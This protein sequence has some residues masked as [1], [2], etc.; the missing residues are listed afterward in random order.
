M[1]KTNNSAEH[2]INREL[3]WL[4]F[5]ARVLEEAVDKRNPLMERL[6]FTAI[7]SSNFDEFFMVR[8][9]S[10]GDQIAA[11]FTKKD[12]S[13]LDP[14]EQMA[15][16]SQRVHG[17]I[18]EQY[19]CFNRS[20]MSLLKKE[21]IIRLE[22]GQ[23]NRQ[24]KDYLKQYFTNRVFPVLTPMVVDQSRPFPLIHNRRLNIALLLEKDGNKEQTLFA[25]VEIPSVLDRL[26]LLPGVGSEKT[27]F[28]LEDLII[29]ELQTLFKGHRIQKMGL[30]RIT[31]NADL[32]YDEEGAED[33]LLTIQESVK[34]RK[35]GSVVRL[36]VQQDLDVFL[37]DILTD[38]LEVYHDAVYEIDGPLDLTFLTAF[39]QMKPF[40]YLRYAPQYPQPL[41]ALSEGEELF[42]TLDRGDVLLHHPYQSFDPVVQ[43]VQLAACDPNVLAI[44]QTLYRVSGNS[45]IIEALAVA[46][47]NGKQVTVLVEL[48][49]RFDE[50]NNILWAKRLEKSGCHVIYGLVGLKTHC[51]ML[52]IVKRSENGIKRYLHMSTGNYNDDTARFYVD[53]GF[54]TSNP[55]FC[56][57]AS[58]IFNMMS[59]YSKLDELYKLML[60][61]LNL[62]QTFLELIEQETRNTAN[63]D[64]GHIIVKV[65]SLVDTELIEA[66]Y[67]AS[68]AGVKIQLLVRGMCCLRPGLPGVSENIEVRSIVAR[69]LEHSRIFYFYH[70]GEELTFL[71]SADWM[72]RN[73]DRRVEVM[74]PVEDL[75]IKAQ[76]KNILD[77][78]LRDTAH[79]RILHADG[80][81]KKINK[82]GKAHFD[83]QEYFYRQAIEEAARIHHQIPDSFESRRKKSPE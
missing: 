19:H 11:G 42:D 40:D 17:L 71:S 27:F 14:V 52:L 51:K 35:W 82:R 62:R 53:L 58:A 60:A 68:R 6:K 24:Q 13:G 3:S 72:E 65:N 29:M 41:L 44:K 28:Y 64:K 61:P 23:L 55:Y 34:Q 45:P 26:I 36:E 77:A 74:F 75:K 9:G 43:M 83:V 8:V 7:V 20:L 21:G 1:K 47:E 48:K 70:G 5:N 16:I 59:G 67:K 46:A 79:T 81:Y 78:Y 15:L 37:L 12:P 73:M 69:F 25:T 50:E 66:L 32:G 4:E 30:F 80:G 39:S 2:F 18:Q 31:R 10:L 22:P 76:I 57:D 49:A 56:A 54:M 63:G 38:K 33:I